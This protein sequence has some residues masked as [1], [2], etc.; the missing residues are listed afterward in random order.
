MTIEIA[1]Q[2]ATAMAQF[3]RA[4]INDRKEIKMTDNEKT[5]PNAFIAKVNETQHTAIHATYA[6]QDHIFD[7]VDLILSSLEKYDP[8]WKAIWATHIEE[9]MMAIRKS[10]SQP[11]GRISGTKK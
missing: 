4:V 7:A 8:R 10:I 11:D 3:V 9:G 2:Q 1:Q 6:L 5:Y